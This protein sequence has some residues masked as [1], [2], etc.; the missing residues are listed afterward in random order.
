MTDKKSSES[1]RK[2]LKSV[3]AGSGAIV[4]GKSLP[5]SWSRPVVD[6]VM[7]PAHAQTS[8]SSP[9]S[10]LSCTP[11]SVSTTA[12]SDD[13]QDDIYIIFDG[14]TVCTVETGAENLPTSPPNAVIGID[15]DPGDKNWDRYYR[16]TG[17]TRTGTDSSGGNNPAGTYYVD[18]SGSAGNFRVTFTVGFSGTEPTMTVS[19]ASASPI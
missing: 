8:P 16:G 1:R 19:N 9:P 11:S 18:V 3:A 4:A 13:S 5:E 6:S 10:P 15:A 12:V 7:L 14:T 2:L 17:W